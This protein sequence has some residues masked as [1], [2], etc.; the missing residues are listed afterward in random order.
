MARLPAGLRRKKSKKKLVGT[1]ALLL[2]A[3]GLALYIVGVKGRYRLDDE[4][5]GGEPGGQSDRPGE[6]A[7]PGTAAAD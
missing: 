4:R 1:A 3:A 7:P 6:A 5:A 2:G